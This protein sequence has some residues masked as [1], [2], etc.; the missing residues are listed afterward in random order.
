MKTLKE[1]VEFQKKSVLKGIIIREGG[2]GENNRKKNLFCGTEN[3]RLMFLTFSTRTKLL[4]NETLAALSTELLE[5]NRLF[6]NSRI[7]IVEGS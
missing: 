1:N 2:G 5:I 6:H 3:E 7:S 4:N